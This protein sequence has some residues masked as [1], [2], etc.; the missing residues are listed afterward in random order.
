MVSLMQIGLVEFKLDALPR[1]SVP[2]SAL[3]SSHGQL[4]NNQLFLVPLLKLNIEPL[5]QQQLILLGS[6]LFSETL[7][8]LF[9]LQ[10]YY[11]VTIN[12]QYLSQQILYFM[13]AQNILRLIF[14]LFE[15]K[16]PLDPCVLDM[17]PATNK[18][19]I[20]LPSHYLN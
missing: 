10:P 12:L 17:F 9:T 19:L 6:L 13:L 5:L 4:R 15:K 1:V 14:I 11:S 18:L 20:F 8:F 7:D 2:I 3:I 16:L